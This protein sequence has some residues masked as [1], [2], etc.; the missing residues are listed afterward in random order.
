[1]AKPKLIRIPMDFDSSLALA[2]KANP[3]TRKKLEHKAKPDR[4]KKES[5]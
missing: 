3:E 4:K 2:V 1:M 5:R